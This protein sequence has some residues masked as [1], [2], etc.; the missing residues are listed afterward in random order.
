MEERKID[1]YLPDNNESKSFQPYD[2]RNFRY[3][4]A[5]DRRVCPEGRKL[6]YLGNYYD[7]QKGKEIRAYKGES[8]LGCPQVKDCTRRKD[9]I[10]Y[11]KMFPG[12]EAR[13]AMQA[14][15]MTDRGKTVYKLR[16]QIVEPVLGD[17]K[18][19]KGLRG[20]LTR[21]IRGVRT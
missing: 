5:K 2:K 4:R 18:E 1:G 13:A 3:D 16:Q 17:L 15:M 10:R 20:F 9:G 19:N 21:G 11:L 6:V 14:K 8:C 7:R 12:E